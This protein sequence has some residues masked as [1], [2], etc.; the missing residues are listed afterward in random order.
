MNDIND[1]LFEKAL[2][3]GITRDEM[4]HNYKFEIFDIVDMEYEKKH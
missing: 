4:Y 2:E 3:N 1:K